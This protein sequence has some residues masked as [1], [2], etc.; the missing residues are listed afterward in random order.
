M[1]R[2]VVY[3]VLGL[4]LVLLS[5][6]GTRPPRPELM[7]EQSG[8]DGAHQ[9]RAGNFEVALRYYF[10]ALAEARRI[11][12]P[13]L[14]ALYQFNIGRILYECVRFDSARIRFSES[15]KLF[16]VSGDTKNAAVAGI[17]EA[18]TLAGLGRGDSAVLLL[19][20]YADRAGEDNEGIVATARTIILLQTGQVA[21]ARKHAELA[22]LLARREKEPFLLGGV[23]YYQAM[24]AFSDGD[25][26]TCRQLLDSSLQCLTSSPY[27]Y[28]NW[29]TLL[30]RAVVDYCSGDSAT[31]YRFYRRAK[32]AAPSLVVFPEKE[33]VT[34]CPERW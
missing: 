18:L 4:C 32:M 14:Q 16:M 25:A 2:V 33:L 28:R 6:A 7:A 34:Q 29:K 9:F 3:T 20:R 26:G 10:K 31:A 23:F 22:M 1:R 13:E 21:A 15:L 17:Y 11:D 27:R 19:R 12:Q 30:G 24:I 5:C 8:Q